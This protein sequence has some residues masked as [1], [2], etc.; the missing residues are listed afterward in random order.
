ML[1]KYYFHQSDQTDLSCTWR[2]R[3]CRPE[4]TW[5]PGVRDHFIVHYILKG[6]GRFSDG[7]NTW[8]LQKG[9]GFVIFPGRLVT[10]TA[11]ATNPWTYSWVGFHGLKAESF[12]NKA[13][14]LSETPVFSIQDVGIACKKCMNKYDFR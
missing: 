12:L 1:E 9:D 2:L 14:I 8:E 4:Y 5:G 6:S 11:D 3:E 10:Y 7:S 13:G